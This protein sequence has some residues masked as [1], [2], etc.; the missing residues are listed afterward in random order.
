MQ[1]TFLAAIVAAIISFPAVGHAE[2]DGPDY[3]M[4]EGVASEDVLNM[5][6]GPSASDSIVGKI[7][8]NATGIRNLGCE[9]GLSFEEWTAATD[10]ERDAAK[11][12]RWCQVEYNGVT[13]WSAGRYLVESA[14]ASVAPAFDCGK[15]SNSAEE[16]VC[17]DPNLARLD[18]ELAR[19]YDLARHGKNTGKDR[20]AELRAMQRG[21]IKGRDEC[22]KS[23]DDLNTCIAKSYVQRIDDL[24]TGYF[25]ARSED[26]AGISSGPFAYICEG[27][28]AGVSMVAVNSDV[29]MISLRWNDKWVIPALEPTGS[30]AKYRGET[31]EGE[32]T[33]WMQGDEAM[34]TTPTQSDLKCQKEE[35]G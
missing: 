18:V 28:D 12:D 33:F 15:A 6:A 23:S 25:D 9:G 10:E 11:H 31:F 4:V 13:G 26:D 24:R 1:K 14:Q 7:P 21:W 16:A 35:I 34:L 5:R 2:A 27:L 3:F 8:P 32:Y 22:W 30:G 19:L 20:L 17:S 29:P